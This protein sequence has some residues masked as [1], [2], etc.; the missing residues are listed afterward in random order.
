[1]TD[2]NP[3]DSVPVDDPA[4][5]VDLA[6]EGLAASI[7][8]WHGK[9]YSV[10]VTSYLSNKNLCLV[11][12]SEAGNVECKAT[13]NMGKL[14]DGTM[15]I[16]NYSENVGVLPVLIARGFIRD[17]GKVIKNGSVVFHLCEATQ[18]LADLTGCPLVAQS[19]GF[20]FDLGASQAIGAFDPPEPP[21]ADTKKAA[22][23]RKSRA[24]KAD[25]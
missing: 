25:K 9:E 2:N 7:V 22:P 12:L 20:A 13:V 8:S 21:A 4:P 15:Y 24:K 18:K 10:Q 11:L 17:T 19:E 14:P 6:W 3:N 1:M 5:V 23:K 16:K